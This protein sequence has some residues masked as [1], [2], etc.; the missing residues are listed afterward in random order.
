MNHMEC[1]IIV[2][3]DPLKFCR[4]E[5]KSWQLACLDHWS[6]LPQALR[7]DVWRLYKNEQ[8]SARHLA[9]VT[10]CHRFLSRQQGEQEDD[11]E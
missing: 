2:S 9:A 1:K 7:D 10:E 8:G 3:H 6:Q 5:K 4:A 11:R